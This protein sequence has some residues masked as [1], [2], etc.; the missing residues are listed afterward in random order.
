MKKAWLVVSDVYGVGNVLY[1][2]TWQFKN[3]TAAV[4]SCKDEGMQ[5]A[6]PRSPAENTRLLHD[7]QASFNTHPNAKKYAHENWVRSKKLK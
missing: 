1:G 6:F 5:I 3:W 2:A 7:I 4:Q